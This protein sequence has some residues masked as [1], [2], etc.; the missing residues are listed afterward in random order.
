MAAPKLRREF[1]ISRALTADV[2][3]GI[4][5]N[6]EKSIKSVLAVDSMSLWSAVAATPVRVP[7]EK[8]MVVELF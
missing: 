6:D 4:M 2:A 8:G 7:T 5:D 1:A 3:R